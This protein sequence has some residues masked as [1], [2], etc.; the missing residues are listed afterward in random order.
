MS[1][2][3]AII[4]GVVQGLTEFVPISSS[5]HLILV[6]NIFG[7]TGIDLSVDAILQLASILAVL[8]YFRI[9]IVRV[10]STLFRHIAGKGVEQGDKNLLY[11]IV[12]GT[13]P[14][15]VLGIL[16]ES[17]METVFRSAHLVAYALIA[18]SAIMFF[19]ERYALKNRELNAKRG[20]MVGCFQALAL[21]PGISRSGATISGGLLAGLSREAATRFSF[22]LSFPIIVG[23]GLKKFLDLSASGSLFDIGAPL[24]L[25]FILSFLVGLLS[26]DL[27]LRYLKN[28]NLHIF[29]WYRLILAFLIIIFL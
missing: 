26:I 25:S 1:Y 14:A 27:L 8:I 19:A 13:I 21:V 6:H 11:A 28:H 24:V 29:V 5:G 9:D 17:K 12:L 4:L 23:S 22:V 18:G 3:E 10:V 16:L 15:F 2:I 20:F 7:E